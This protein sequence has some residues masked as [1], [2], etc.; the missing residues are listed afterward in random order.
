MAPISR[1][2]ELRR[3]MG[4]REE[5]VSAI[6]NGPPLPLKGQVVGVKHRLVI[7]VTAAEGKAGIG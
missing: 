2:R 3:V 4:R 7:G 6:F 5:L 1:T